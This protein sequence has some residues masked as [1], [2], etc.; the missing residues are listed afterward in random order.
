[1][2]AAAGVILAG[3]AATRIGG[4]KA[5]LPFLSGTLLDAVI[6]RVQHQVKRLSLSV[7]ADWAAPARYGA[8]ALLI[9]PYPERIGPLGGIVAGLEWLRSSGDESWLATFP[10]DTPFLPMDLVAQLI[11]KA[12]DRPIVARDDARTQ[13]VCAVWPL[14]CA[15]RLRKGVEDGKLRSLVSA[16][17]ALGGE[18]C[19]ISADAHAFFN[20]NTSEDLATAVRLAERSRA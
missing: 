20:V 9:D 8:Y 3:G 7:P 12:S 2:S 4:E 14:S 10:C 16:M 15:E 19:F 17:D 1:M 6:S 18:T 5:L 13:G 11:A